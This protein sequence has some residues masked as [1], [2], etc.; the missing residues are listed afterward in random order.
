MILLKCCTQYASKFG[1][2]SSGH[3]TGTS[4]FIP[5]PK[6]RQCRLTF[7]KYYENDFVP[8]WWF[9]YLQITI[10]LQSFHMLEKLCSKFF[11]LGFSST[12]TENFQIYKQ[13]WEKAEEPE[14]K[15]STFAGSERKQGNFRK[16][17]TSVLLTTRKPLTVWITTNYGKFLKRWEYQSTLPLSRETCMQEEKQQLEPD[18]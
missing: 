12:W 8:R 16:T 10:Q 15:L 11:K 6:K 9:V 1:K 14:I 5:I 18:I 2:L 17:S 7:F 13:G 3:R 4:V